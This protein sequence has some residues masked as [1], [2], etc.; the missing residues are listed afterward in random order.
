MTSAET[1]AT[2]CRVALVGFGSAGRGIHGPLLA[3]AG[4]APCI[5]VTANPQRARQVAEDLPDAVVVPDLDAALAGRPDLVV[6]ASPSGVH[7]EQAQ[8]CVRAG[9]PVVVD[10]PLAVDARHARETVAAA[11]SACVPLTVF[12]NRRWDPENLTLA[13]LL[14]QGALGQVHRFERRWERWR[15]VPKDRWRESA[16]AAQGGGLLLDLGPHLVDAALWLFGPARRVYGETAAWTTPAEDDVFISIEHLGGVRSHLSATSVAAAPGPRTRVLGARA[17][18]VVTRF[19][20]EAAAFGGFD[21]DPGHCGWLVTGEQRSPVSS[22][23]GG[24]GD[25]Y[26]AVLA[27]LALADPVA[28]QAAMP[29][30]PGDAVATAVVLDAARLSAAEHRTITL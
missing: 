23:P 30:Q 18:Y 9:V 27:A 10:K 1:P 26:P 8:A 21:D 20:A 2:A 28:R 5:V 25:F 15:P 14:A 7:G 16:L 22:A 19:E 13:R 24:V 6:V 3:Q 4:A 29:V 12:Q 11:R 17:A